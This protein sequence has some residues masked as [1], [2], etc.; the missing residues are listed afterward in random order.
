M[1]TL[2]GLEQQTHTED[3]SIGHN[4]E[5]IL[6]RMNAGIGNMKLFE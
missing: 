4:N 2:A 5:P 3:L 6:Q 1:K